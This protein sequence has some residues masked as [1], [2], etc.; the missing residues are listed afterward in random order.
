GYNTTWG[1]GDYSMLARTQVGVGVSET[2]PVAGPDGGEFGIFPNLFSEHGVIKYRTSSPEDLI[3]L[4]VY[5]VRGELRRQWIYDS[6]TFPIEF[7]WDGTDARGRRLP[8]GVYFLQLNG[9]G[10]S[11]IQKFI[12]LR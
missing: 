3:S 2:R 8:G 1:W 9:K 4:N 10:W 7:F 5:D 6:G 11:R 12:I